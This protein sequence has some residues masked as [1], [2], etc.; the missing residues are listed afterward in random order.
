MKYSKIYLHVPY[1]QKD[2]AKALGARWDPANKKW[3]VPANIDITP[4]AKWQSATVTAELSSTTT[5]K[6]KVHTPYA[7]NSPSAKNENVDAITYSTIK[8][9]VA[10]N[11]DQP[12]WE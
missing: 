4:F 12:P 7:K 9:F 3:Y 6:P 10:Y 5:N 1:T 11:G 2:A 8:D